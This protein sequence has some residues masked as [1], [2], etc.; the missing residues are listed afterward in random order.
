MQNMKYHIALEVRACLS[1]AQ[2]RTVML[3]GRMRLFVY[4]RLV[5]VGKEKYCLSKSAQHFPTDRAGL[6]FLST[7]Y[8]SS[9]NIVNAIPFLNQKYVDSD[10][11]AN[12]ILLYNAA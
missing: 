8:S 2:K 9:L 12:I 1:N 6:N 10:M 5:S 7:A 11:M 4:S 3:N